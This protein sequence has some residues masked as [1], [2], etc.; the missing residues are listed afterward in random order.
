M[1][2]DNE[3]KSIIT[4]LRAGHDP[5]TKQLHITEEDAFNAIQAIRARDRADENYACQR[6]VQATWS[7]SD[8]LKQMRAR[9]KEES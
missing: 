6:I 2:D 8:Q 4:K 7:T 1:N 5:D 3:I 9:V